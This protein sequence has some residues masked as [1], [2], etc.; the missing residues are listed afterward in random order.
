MSQPDGMLTLEMP[1]QI[2]F[3]GLWDM[4]SVPYRSLPAATLQFTGLSPY[5][6]IFISELVRKMS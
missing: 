4:A 5:A 1:C 2:G 3:T 6:K